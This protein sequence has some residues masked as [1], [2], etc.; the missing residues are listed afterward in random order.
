MIGEAVYIAGVIIAALRKALIVK[1]DL[2][3][4]KLLAP[5]YIIRLR[6]ICLIFDKISYIG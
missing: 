5:S 4:S 6:V 3:M 1:V 2:E